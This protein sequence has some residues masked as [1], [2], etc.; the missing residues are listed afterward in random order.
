MELKQYGRMI[1]KR[2][3]YILAFVVIASMAAGL[4]SFY[5][6]KPVYEAS[7][8]LI[9]NKS[10][11][12]TGASPVDIGLIDANIRLINTYKEIILTPA[13]MDIVA[14]RYPDL[15][16]TTEELMSKVKVSSINNTQVMTL[17]MQDT[18]YNRAARTVNAVAAVFKT[19]IPS[20]M[21][22]DNVTILNEAKLLP[23]P[24]PVKPNHMLNILI[25]LVL[26]LMLATGAVFVIEYMDDTIK[27]E[28][29]V[30]QYL[31]LPT[32]SVVMKT[33]KADMKPRSS[34]GQ[35][36]TTVMITNEH[37]G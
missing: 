9:V 12:Q 25:G 4:V 19:E 6:I 33:K 36:E 34:S 20:I 37:S 11:E 32:L 29:D 16:L 31:Q 35:R 26:S 28:T 8:K 23:N 7:N 17:I 2:L 10:N 5:Y 18:S 22:V 30:E 15:Q 27:S 21:K 1:R 14:V 24:V 13:I 3:W